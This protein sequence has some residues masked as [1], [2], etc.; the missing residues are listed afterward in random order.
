MTQKIF[1]H[2]FILCFFAQF[3]FTSVFHILIPTLPIYLSKSGSSEVEIGVLIGVLGISSL[4]LRP[5]VGRGL[6]KIPE[7][8]F[9]I[10]GTLIFAL[11]S[12]AYLWAAPFWPFLMVR[13]FQGIGL[14]FF[15]TASV[16]LIT[17]ISP[18]TRR[19]QSISYFYLAFNLSFALSPSLGMLLINNFSFTL[20]FLFCLGLSLCALFLTTRLKRGEVEALEDPSQQDKSF[21]SRDALPIAIISFFSHI[22]WGGLTAFFPLYAIEKGV[23]N[24]GYFFAAYASVIILGRVFGGKILDL[25]SRERVILPCLFTYIISMTLLAFSETLL[26]F[27]LVAMIWGIGTAFLMPSLVT[28]ALDRAG[29]SRGP[30]IGTLSAIGDLGVALGPVITGII[31]RLTSYPIMFLFLALTGII[32]LTYFYYFVRKGNR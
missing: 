23:A 29:S 17:N 2:N 8:N 22:V 13:I 7:K 24:P 31:L 25:Y 18:V 9:M 3:T 10:A 15:Y 14:A 4:I 32:N 1:T 20:L 30:A 27:I 28:Y 19:G 26:M 6:I 12:V 21:L 16:T 11:T 5:I